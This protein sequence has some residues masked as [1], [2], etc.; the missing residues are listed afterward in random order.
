MAKFSFRLQSIL[1]LKIRLEDQQRNAFAA[2][3]RAL[4]EEEDKLN[5]LYSRLDFYEEEGRRLRDETLVIRDLIDNEH[6]ISLVKDYIEDQK[7]Q[8][9]L[10]EARLEDERLKLVEMIKE[11]QTY[12]KLREKAFEEFLETEKHEESVANDEHNSFV[13]KVRT[14]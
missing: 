9:R 4:D 6:A 10:A 1:N 8:V 5:M 12:E 13:Y 11:R 2:A 3:K 7:A 14:T